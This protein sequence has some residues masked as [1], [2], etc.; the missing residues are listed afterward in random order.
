MAQ[1]DHFRTPRQVLRLPPPAVPLP[2]LRG[3]DFDGWRLD[4][5]RNFGFR[6]RDPVEQGRPFDPLAASAE[7]HLHQPMDVGLLRVDLR[8]EVGHDAAEFRDHGLGVSQ[9]PAEVVDVV[10]RR[11]AAWNTATRSG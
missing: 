3:R 7:R 11:H 10:G 1:V 8:A 6:Q 4:R 9:L 2:L 5:R